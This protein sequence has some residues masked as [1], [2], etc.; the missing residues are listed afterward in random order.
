MYCNINK[1]MTLNYIFNIQD[2]NYTS[3]QFSK[4]RSWLHSW[5]IR[6]FKTWST[7]QHHSMSWARDLSNRNRMAQKGKK[8]FSPIIYSLSI[9]LLNNSP[10]TQSDWHF[11]WSRDI[12]T[13][14]QKQ[15]LCQI[16]PQRGRTAKRTTWRPSHF[17]QFEQIIGLL[18]AD[19]W[20]VPTIWVY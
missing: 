13:Y 17:L 18:E 20:H 8:Y 19:I 4:F 16:N 10:T 1:Q 3:I 11:D 7:A 14:R 6:N 12:D 2:Q 15:K 9:T 5:Q